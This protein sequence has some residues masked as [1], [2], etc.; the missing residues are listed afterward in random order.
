MNSSTV[1]FIDALEPFIVKVFSGEKLKVSEIM[2]YHQL[3]ND[4]IMGS[5]DYNSF[6]KEFRNRI[7]QQ[8]EKSV[9][10]LDQFSGNDNFNDMVAGEIKKF[11]YPKDQFATLFKQLGYAVSRYSSMTPD[12]FLYH[13]WDYIFIFKVNKAF[14][15]NYPYPQPIYIHQDVVLNLN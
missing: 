10:Y 14:G 6:M 15:L 8:M 5:F 9:Q 3:V 4:Y 7:E 1:P 13:L 2:P 12:D 11:D